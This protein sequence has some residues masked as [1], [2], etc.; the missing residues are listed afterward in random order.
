M[1]PTRVPA[2]ELESR[3]MEKLL[4]FL[5]S[6]T[7]VFDG[8]DLAGE[9]PA[10]A[11]RLL[12][13]AK[14]LATRLPSMFSQELRELLASVLWRITLQE[15]RIEINI[16]SMQLRHQLDS[17]GPITSPSVPAKPTVQHSSSLLL[18]V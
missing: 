18:R 12:T 2:Q 5:K 7:E 11:S 4:A 6:D 15:N 9:R 16:S 3:V 14:Q 1:S 10:V 13:A 8:L 17:G